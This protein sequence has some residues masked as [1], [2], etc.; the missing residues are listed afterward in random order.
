MASVCS[1]DILSP[2][3]E[4]GLGNGQ[5][6]IGIRQN[7]AAAVSGGAAGVAG[8]FVK[9]MSRRFTLHPLDTRG[10]MVYSYYER[11][12]AGRVCPRPGRGDAHAGIL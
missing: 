1:G 11:N 5:W 6:A 2:F 7:V 10:F 12:I 9:M 3:R 4:Q 8:G